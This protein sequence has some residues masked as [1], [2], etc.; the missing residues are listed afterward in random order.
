MAYRMSLGRKGWAVEQIRAGIHV[1]VWGRESRQKSS[2]YQAG[3][4]AGVPVLMVVVVVPEL[5]ATW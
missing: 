1:H 4:A 5:E 3:Y 2:T